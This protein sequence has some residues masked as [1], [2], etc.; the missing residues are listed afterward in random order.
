MNVIQTGT[1]LFN[2]EDTNAFT[3][4]IKEKKPL[5]KINK[6]TELAKSYKANYAPSLVFDCKYVVQ[7]HE[8][9]IKILDS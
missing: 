9:A 8:N 2:I 4:C 6:E 7:G 5:E 1:L 3:E